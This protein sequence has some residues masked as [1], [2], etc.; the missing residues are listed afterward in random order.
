MTNLA[1]S[2]NP[3]VITASPV[4]IACELQGGEIFVLGDHRPVSKD[5]RSVGCFAL[6][7][8]EGVV[9]DWSIDHK[10]LLK[11][12]EIFRSRFHLFGAGRETD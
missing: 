8:V 4:R 10:D 3:G 7:D 6:A 2:L 5:S 9:T 11:Q 12:F 1:G